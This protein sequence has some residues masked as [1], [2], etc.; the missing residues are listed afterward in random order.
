VPFEQAYVLPLALRNR[1]PAC[2]P[3]ALRRAAGVLR[4]AAA[5]RV[6]A[7]RW[8]DRR[9]ERLYP[10]PY[11]ELFARK[12]R[13]VVSIVSAKSFLSLAFEPIAV[14]TSS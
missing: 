1:A 11:L 2:S 7:D 10:G 9:I 13:G 12:P 5:R 6:A 3:M 14:L 4:S 8:A